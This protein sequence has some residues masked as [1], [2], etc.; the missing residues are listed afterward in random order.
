[1]KTAWFADKEFA[2]N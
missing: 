2:G 1:M